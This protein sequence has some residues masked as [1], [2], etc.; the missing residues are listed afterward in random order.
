MSKDLSS[1]N[2]I[3]IKWQLFHINTFHE[4]AVHVNAVYFS[5]V[6]VSYRVLPE[7]GSERF[8]CSEILCEQ[9][10][11]FCNSAVLV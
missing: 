4:D 2:Y 10:L 9:S 11:A 1:K 7:N 8:P 6:D 5:I 3:P